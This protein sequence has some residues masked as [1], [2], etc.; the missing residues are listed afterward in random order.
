LIARSL[1][2]IG[3]LAEAISRSSSPPDFSTD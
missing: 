2:A 1:R 3:S